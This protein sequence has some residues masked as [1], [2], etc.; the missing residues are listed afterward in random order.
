MKKEKSKGWEW[1]SWLGGIKLLLAKIAL[2]TPK[3]DGDKSM[4]QFVFERYTKKRKRKK[5]LLISQTH[6]ESNSSVLEIYKVYNYNVDIQSE[7]LKQDDMFL[8]GYISLFFLKL[9][10]GI[11]ELK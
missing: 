11:R 10:C 4:F 8:V 2:I 6:I 9:I 1:G 7:S 5:V 3:K